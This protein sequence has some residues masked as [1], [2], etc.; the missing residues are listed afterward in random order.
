MW[1]YPTPLVTYRLRRA[2]DDCASRSEWDHLTRLCRT[3]VGLHEQ[4][5]HEAAQALSSVILAIVTDKLDAEYGASRQK[6]GSNIRRPR[7]VKN[8]PSGREFSDNT[9]GCISLTTGC[10]WL[11]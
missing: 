2:L 7:P 6:F 4:G 1:E 11:P 9:L 10:S 5:S 8:E 3:A